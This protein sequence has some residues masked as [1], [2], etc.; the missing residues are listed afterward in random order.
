MSII[1]AFE[2][3]PVYPARSALEKAERIFVSIQTA[4][5]H[6]NP[7]TENIRASIGNY[8]FTTMNASSEAE[9]N[10]YVLHVSIDK[11][12]FFSFKEEWLEEIQRLLNMKVSVNNWTSIYL[13]LS[14]CR[15]STEGKDFHVF[16]LQSFRLN[17]NQA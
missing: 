17:S 14:K 6:Y 4:M 15:P 2:A 8:Q 12:W 13:P 5:E 10:L 7:L 3:F 11:P 9:P 16:R 1:S